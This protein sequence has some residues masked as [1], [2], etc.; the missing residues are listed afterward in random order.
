M[1]EQRKIKL[2]IN[3]QK[4][5]TVEA[6]LLMN[7]E[8]YESD[9]I[10]IEVSERT[11]K[12][13]QLGELHLKIKNEV[14][15]ERFN[16]SMERPI[17]IYLP[18]QECPEK[19]TAMYLFNAWWTRPAFVER[20]QDIPDRTQVAFFKYADRYAC[21]VPMIGNRFKTYMVSGSETEL[22]LEM[23]AHMGGQAQVDEPLYL[24][25]EADTV[26][27]A[28]HKVFMLLAETKGICLRE[29][30]RIP[31]MFR[32][33]GWCSW[34]AFYTDV[35]EEK[36]R[37]KADEFIEKQV[38]VKWMLIDD[39]WFSSQDKM[40]YDF[41]PDKAKFPHGFKNMIDDIRE[42]SD[43]KWFGI[44]HALGGY[45]GGISPESDLV[46][47]EASYLYQTAD[48]SIVPSPKTGSGF[49]N[50]WC[51]VL[52]REKIDFIKVDGQSATPFYFENCLPVSEA[53]R[54]MNQAL[55][56]GAYRMDGA[57]INC[58]GM[59][60]ENIL[61]RP[62]SAI[63]RNS[64][65][66][67]P[68]KEEGFSEHLLQNA[69]NAIYHNE[70]YCCDWDMF[71]TEHEDSV[72][73]SLLRAISG[74]PIYFSDKIGNTNPKVLK[75]LMYEDGRLL[76]M[77]RSAKPTED[78]I[79]TDP[80][81][82]GVL[83]LHNV[84]PWGA[85]RK[86]G[87]IAAYNLTT[88]QQ[89]VTFMPADIPDLA[90]SDQYWVYDYFERKVRSLGRNEIY[91]DTVESRGFA[92]YV[93]LP[94]G[95]NSTC[96]GLLD[97]YAGF[98]AVESIHEG[99]DAEIVVLQASGTLGW[100]SP[101]EPKIVMIDAVDVTKEVKKSGELYILSLPETINKTVLSIRW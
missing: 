87:G 38:P 46:L 45:W 69:Y 4:R 23:T 29:K 19:I 56:S 34:D 10:Y 74:G 48:G 58:M 47:Q 59:A 25:A 9:G 51:E 67:V 84:A 89:T 94:Q 57:I 24:Y 91:E 32:H 82:N 98:S 28:V 93:I 14:L 63:S 96:L 90:V 86:G 36:I 53:A 39:G 71:W 44:W 35:T 13:C 31:E 26:T 6:E 80:M 12:G 77:D 49:Y 75:P 68:G 60:M 1:T 95:K 33:L 99:E 66:F 15:S 73:H 70:L 65:D 101:K 30:R 88:Q 50:D 76:M 85:D 83:K 42:K 100:A 16:L 20:L 7:T 3:C 41:A 22:C 17:R 55:E 11:E 37:Q 64:D 81:E 27:E 97:K 5:K 92:W 52:K 18:M 62:V 79:F 78:C 72:K 43:I 8:A 54:G 40:L 21:F 61:A 2:Q